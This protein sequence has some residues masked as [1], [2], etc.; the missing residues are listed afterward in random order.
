M[1]FLPGELCCVSRAC[2]LLDTAGGTCGQENLLMDRGFRTLSLMP[3][4]SLRD[5]QANPPRKS[6]HVHSL[7]LLCI[8]ID[9]RL[10]ADGAA[11]F[12]VLICNLQLR[13]KVWCD[14]CR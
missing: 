11:R 8:S 14:G 12:D 6:L 9:T 1:P 7:E 2:V 5:G 10:F 4:T 3:R 13:L